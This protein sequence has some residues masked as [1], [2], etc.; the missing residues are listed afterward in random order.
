MRRWV[1]MYFSEKIKL[2]DFLKWASSFLSVEKP[3]R[4]VGMLGRR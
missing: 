1:Y 4:G 3:V 2:H